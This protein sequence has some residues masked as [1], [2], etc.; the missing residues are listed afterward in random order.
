[1]FV[2]FNQTSW[3]FK[4]LYRMPRAVILFYNRRQQKP[5]SFSFS[6]YFLSPNYSFI[7]YFSLTFFSLMSIIS[8]YNIALLEA[9][10]VVHQPQAELM[11][12]A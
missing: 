2:S 9:V 10:V 6:I 1:M 8:N 7:Q 5:M 3:A 11:M 12:H 4:N